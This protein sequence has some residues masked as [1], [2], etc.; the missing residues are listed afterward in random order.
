M[1]MYRDKKMGDLMPLSKDSFLGS[2]GFSENPFDWTNADEEP[3]L[4]TY[5]VPPPYFASVVGSPT[6]PKSV[7][8]FAP[9]GAG[10][11]A[12]KVMIENE[13]QLSTNRND[14]KFL[15][16]SYDDFDTVGVSNI[17]QITSAWHLTNI[18]RKIILGIILE[19]ESDPS[20]RNRLSSTQKNWIASKASAFLSDIRESEFKQT[21]D[22]IR[23]I[24]G[25]TEY[26][27]SKYGGKISVLLSS[28]AEFLSAGK[29]DGISN[30][31]DKTSFSIVEYIRECQKISKTLGFHSI[32][33]LI[34]R[35]DETN[36]T[37]TSAEHSFT[38]ISPILTDLH[39][40]EIEGIC[41][42]FFLWDKMK[43]FY[44]EKGGRPDR[45][46]I[47]QIEW[48]VEQ[49]SIMLSRRLS[50]YSE[51]KIFSLNDFF[52]L[53][54]PLDFHSIIAHLSNGSPRDMIRMCHRIVDEHTKMANTKSLVNFRSASK[55]ISKFSEERSREIYGT[56]V[57][58]MVRF[59][60]SRFSKKEM[61]DHYLR[62]E[63]SE[64][65]NSVNVEKLLKQWIDRGGISLALIDDLDSE[66]D[67]SEK[68]LYNVTDPRLVITVKSNQMRFAQILS[69]CFY[70]CKSCTVVGVSDQ[71]Y[72]R[73]YCRSCGR[74]V[75]KENSMLSVS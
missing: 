16:I 62:E 4:S 64:D 19:I 68:H 26:I 57:D 38:F 29:L 14:Y 7:I 66:D 58:G 18:F 47:H 50:S 49:I 48:S 1:V 10:K 17:D 2:L 23:N 11:T 63:I 22:S 40:L 55:G 73:I 20:S 6:R 32:Y 5:F 69:E 46:S 51:G 56:I 9:R 36:L 75:E 27:W 25:K 53:E 24:K 45:I 71:D 41:F 52:G 60:R 43:S 33:I 12:Q 30:V 35:V 44:L 31:V 34:D 21:L 28:I 74:M 67:H 42:K 61:I 8:V 54:N 72:E 3:Y 70:I 39:L 37:N 65:N 59:G 13:S 15:C